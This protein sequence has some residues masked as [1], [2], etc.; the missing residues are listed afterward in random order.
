MKFL[1]PIAADALTRRGDIDIFPIGSEPIFPGIGKVS[2]FAVS[3]LAFLKGYLR[4]N[5]VGE[6]WS[7]P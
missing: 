7:D 6:D 3:L 5:A 4:P 2:D 1:N